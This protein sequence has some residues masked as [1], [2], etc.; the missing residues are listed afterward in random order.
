MRLW[1]RYPSVELGVLV[2]Q[3]SGEPRRKRF[4]PLAVVEQWRDTAAHVGRDMALHLC[5]PYSRAV[6][7]G[8][9]APV[10]RLSDGF[11]RVQVNATSY[12][13]ERIAQ[14]AEASSCD[15]VILQQRYPPGTEPP[16]RHHKVEYL[17]DASGGR[18]LSDFSA[19]AAPIDMQTR[20]GYAGG[21]G[22]AN[23]DRAIGFADEF[24]GFR[25]W[26]DMESGIRDPDDWLDL[27]KAEAVCE[28]V[29]GS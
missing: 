22:P 29:F 8:N 17:Q 13:Y 24:N 5:G 3:H 20:W 26:L 18:G 1:D 6:M 15:S 23:I 4:P 21:L 7:E 2:G 11:R 19:W 14:F 10:L 28:A 12:N 27:N 25:L 16:L 9:T